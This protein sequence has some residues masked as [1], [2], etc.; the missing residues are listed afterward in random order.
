METTLELQTDNQ[1]VRLVE[2]S[3]LDKN[4]A[5]FILQKFQDFFAIADEWNTKAKSL[6]VTD[7][8]QV[9]EMKQAREGR[10]FLKGK[11]VEVEKARKELK[12]QSLREGQTIDGIARVLTNLI[13]PI[14]DHL[15]EQ[16]KFKE[17]KDAEAKSVRTK[18]RIARVSPFGAVVYENMIADMDDQM[19]ESY[20]HGVKKLYEDRIAEEQKEELEREAREKAEAE[21]RE[22][23]RQEN[24]K[25]KKEAEVREAAILKERKLAEQKR[26]AVE[27]AAR[28]EREA[29]DALAEKVREEQEKKLKAEREERAKAEAALKAKEDEEKKAEEQR[30]AA[31]EADLSRGDK[32]KFTSL[33]SDLENLKEKY[34]FKS[35]KYRAIQ[36]SMNALIDKTI[37]Y[38]KTKV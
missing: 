10:L 11:R 38:A 1:L 15:E 5:D 36:V 19:F 12:E 25:L 4:K 34:S 28:K 22:K 37:D 33:L 6:V 29:A 2:T 20:Y 32:S 18:E 8:S 17:R 21:E 13:S 35:K 7:V 3:G 24:E 27:G 23:I 14:E 30:L 31:I 26:K 16:E 9:E